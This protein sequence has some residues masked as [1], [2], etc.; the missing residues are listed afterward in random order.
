[1]VMK[2]KIGIFK[3]FAAGIVAMS[4]RASKTLQIPPFLRSQQRP[5]PD[6]DFFS[7]IPDVAYHPY[8][9]I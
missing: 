5:R 7:E 2:R 1:M 8:R 9:L 6:L 3:L 4:G